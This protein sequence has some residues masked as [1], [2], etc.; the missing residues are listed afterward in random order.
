LPACDSNGGKAAPNEAVKSDRAPLVPSNRR[1]A[2]RGHSCPLHMGGAA[3]KLKRRLMRDRCPHARPP[4]IAL[5]K[6]PCRSPHALPPPP[7]SSPTP[8]LAPRTLEQ[9]LRLRH[10][11]VHPLR[12]DR[13][14]LLHR[15]IHRLIHRHHQRRKLP[16]PRKAF[17]LHEQ[18]QN[19]IGDWIT[20]PS[21]SY[22]ARSASMSSLCRRR[23]W[24]RRAGRGWAVMATKLMLPSSDHLVAQKRN[25][26]N[27]AV[28]IG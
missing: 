28:L 17:M 21:F 2:E 27:F 18:L 1:G 10:Q 13:R 4:A 6:N 3:A 15:L 14:L 24:L 16:Q 26:S 12:R 9:M 8:A 23:S 11:R 25:L 19:C 7:Q 20:F 5:S 22:A